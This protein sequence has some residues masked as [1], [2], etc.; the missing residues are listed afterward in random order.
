MSKLPAGTGWLWLKHGFALFRKQPGILTMLLF[1]NLMISLLVS[2]VPFV[3]PMLAIILIPS[4][5]IAI[6]QACFD[7]EQGKRVGPAVLMTGF[8]QPAF[9]ALCKLGLVYLAL[10][11]LLAL[12]AKLTIDPDVMRQ[13]S[14]SAEQ[15]AAAGPNAKPVNLQP[16]LMVF[17]VQL[18]ALM[19]VMAMS[20][21]SPLTYWQKM[22]PLKATFYS[23]FAVLGAIKPILVM[24]AAWFGIFM[25][26]AMAVVLILG[27][28]NGG[29]VVFVWIILISALLLQCAI[30]AS[31]RQIF[32][33]PAD[34]LKPAP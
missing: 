31:Y 17:V 27:N 8:R 2:A 26:V 5:S 10:S 1:A 22:P 11:L 7:I 34:H 3:G 18:F 6:M 30:Y 23:V 25:T 16:L 12:L 28:G 15:A 32:G 21:S 29:K 20:F 24:L 4:L 13:V 33:D 19:A 9:H 14:A